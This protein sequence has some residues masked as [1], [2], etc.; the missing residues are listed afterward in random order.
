M[1]L[2]C[3]LNKNIC[4]KNKYFLCALL[5][6]LEDHWLGLKKVFSL[7]KN[8]NKKWTMRVD[9][10]DHEG[11]AA[12]AEYRNFRLTNEKTAF[13]LHVGTYSG[14]AGTAG[15]AF[16][17]TVPLFPFSFYRHKHCLILSL[18]PYLQTISTVV[19]YCFNKC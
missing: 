15:S 16:F 8:K 17:L 9:L 5:I 10:W 7:T 3:V 6:P 13:K 4:Q 11:G 1:A 2:K 19:L 12:F 14:N 18:L